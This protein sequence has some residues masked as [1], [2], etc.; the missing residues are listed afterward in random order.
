M[1]DP[2]P[3]DVMLLFCASVFELSPPHTPKYGCNS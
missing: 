2:L 1:E 3:G